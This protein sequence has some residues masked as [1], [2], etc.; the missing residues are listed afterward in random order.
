MATTEKDRTGQKN[1]RSVKKG[2]GSNKRDH[3]EQKM[4]PMVMS[5][6]KGTPD[7]KLDPTDP[8]P[9]EKT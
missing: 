3:W 7:L 1:S 2:G 9:W 6:K 5:E 8:F 4:S